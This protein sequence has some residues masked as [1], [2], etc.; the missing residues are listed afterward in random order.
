MQAALMPAQAGYPQPK[1]LSRERLSVE[2][3]TAGQDLHQQ[4]LDYRDGRP[5]RRLPD[6]LP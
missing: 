2:T 6:S 3:L 5:L 1:L 4:W